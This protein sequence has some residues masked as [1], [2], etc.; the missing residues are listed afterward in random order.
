MACDPD[1]EGA[2][3]PE[4]GVT[5]AEAL[6]AGMILGLGLLA[7]TQVLIGSTRASAA[8]D[9]RT[10]AA[11]IATSQIGE[12]RSLDY[13][14]LGID[15]ADSDAV[16]DFEGLTTVAG[17]VVL[18]D[19]LVSLNV[20]GTDYEV[21]RHLVWAS[22]GSDSQAYKRLVVIVTWTVGATTFDHR[23]DTGVHP[24]VGS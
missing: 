12:L 7:V 22:V 15:A 23:V 2:R 13:D 17:T 14:G 5:T 18:L 19:P 3:S 4:R 6:V 1:D 9:D 20:D 24:L 10:V 11:R 8:A 16:A 21:R